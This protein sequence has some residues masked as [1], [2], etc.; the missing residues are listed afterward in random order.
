ML[1]TG[2]QEK[3]HPPTDVSVSLQCRPQLHLVKFENL[4]QRFISGCYIGSS[5]RPP[6]PPLD[7]IWY[8]ML[9][10]DMADIVIRD[11]F[12]TFKTC[13]KST[14]K[15]RCYS[16]FFRCT[17]VICSDLVT[18]NLGYCCDFIKI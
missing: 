12:K 4:V 10:Y 16:P 7:M 3:L 2:Q 13:F 17:Y 1:K 6:H 8:D 18:A 14:R 5:G 15:L 9:W 11:A